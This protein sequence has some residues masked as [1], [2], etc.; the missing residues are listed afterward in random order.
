MA[1]F[2]LPAIKDCYAVEPFEM[3]PK[4][5]RLDAKKI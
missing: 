4:L 5:R 3:L 2:L 1:R